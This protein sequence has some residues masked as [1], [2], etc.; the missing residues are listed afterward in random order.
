MIETGRVICYIGLMQETKFQGEIILVYESGKIYLVEK[1]TKIMNG[2]L[3]NKQ[4]II[5]IYLQDMLAKLEKEKFYGR[6]F[7]GIKEKK[8]YFLKEKEQIKNLN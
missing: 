4:E 7:I 8:L 5:L 1:E 2:E 6:L 3:E